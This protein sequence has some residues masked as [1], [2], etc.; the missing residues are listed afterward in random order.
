MP[1]IVLHVSGLKDMTFHQRDVYV[2]MEQV[3][4]RTINQ[5]VPWKLFSFSF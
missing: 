1:L 3:Y 5:H 2:N 4:D